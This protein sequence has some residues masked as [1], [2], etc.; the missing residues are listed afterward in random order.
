MAGRDSWRALWRPSIRENTPEGAQVR[1]AIASAFDA[2]Q[3]KVTEILGIE[4]GYQ[5][6]DSPV[7]WPEAG[8]RPDPNSVRYVPTTWPGARL[9]HVWLDD[10]TALHDRLGFDGFTLLK[11]RTSADTS[12]FERALRGTGMPLSVLSV[13]D[14]AVRDLYGCDLLLVRPDLHVAWR[15]DTPPAHPDSVAA[16]VTGR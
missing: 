13:S 10:G 9:P 8:E 6:V 3:R 16:R 11:L 14:T 2:E 15:G 12:P 4:A 1:S 7:I 5:Y